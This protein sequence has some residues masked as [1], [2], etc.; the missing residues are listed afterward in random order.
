MKN[1][2]HKTLEKGT[3][4]SHQRKS[5]TSVSITYPNLVLW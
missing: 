2:H 3:D 1:K 4:S 5:I